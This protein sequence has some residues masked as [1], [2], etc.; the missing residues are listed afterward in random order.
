MSSLGTLPP[1]DLGP[2]MNPILTRDP[3]AHDGAMLPTGHPA[4]E[5][6]FSERSSS[7]DTVTQCARDQQA[8]SSPTRNTSNSK[9]KTQELR[10]KFVSLDLKEETK[11]DEKKNGDENDSK[12]GAKRAVND[13]VSSWPSQKV[14]LDEFTPAEERMP[15]QIPDRSEIQANSY[16]DLKSWLRLGQANTHSWKLTGKLAL[17][18]SNRDGAVC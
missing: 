13:F 3:L 8:T 6:L 16:L 11:K 5:G 18:L 15:D 14:C 10:T 7:I 2:E 1:N 4:K 12:K 17:L 9:R